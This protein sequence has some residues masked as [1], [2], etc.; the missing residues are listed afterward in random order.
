MSAALA[1]DV[2]ASKHPMDMQSLDISLLIV[3][4]VAELTACMTA[5]RVAG[6][7]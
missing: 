6:E 5:Q 1:T 7:D 2:A 4:V 3:A